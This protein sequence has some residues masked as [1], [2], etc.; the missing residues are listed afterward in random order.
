MF[1]KLRRRR[2]RPAASPVPPPAAAAAAAAATPALADD[3]MLARIDRVRAALVAAGVDF[4][5]LGAAREPAWFA[6]LRNGQRLPL[7]R[8]ELK[9][10]ADH[11][12]G[13][14][15]EAV[16]SEGACARLLS[17]IEVLTTLREL[18]EE[19]MDLRFCHG[20]LPGDAAAVL[21]LA[22]HVR[23]QVAA[24]AGG[25]DDAAARPGNAA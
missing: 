15:V 22:D 13:I 21:S 11:L 7:G 4:E 19:G 1:D 14:A 25:D 17:H 6:D 9:E 2:P 8:A 10:T 5:G 18:K 12:P 3:A 24:A 20:G 16:L 23:D